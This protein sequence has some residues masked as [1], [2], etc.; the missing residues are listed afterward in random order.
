MTRREVVTGGI[1]AGAL[2]S[3]S[4]DTP[5]SAPSPVPQKDSDEKVVSLLTE[6]REELRRARATCNANDCQEVERV[7]NEQRTFLKGRN[8]FPDYIDVGADI[9]DRLCDWHIKNGLPL[10]VSRLPEG[11]YTLPF[12]QTFVVLKSDVANSYVSQGYDK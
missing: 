6:I 12:F 9:W 11:R 3:A 8:K 7:R 4:A 10:Q 5:A 1:V 2:A